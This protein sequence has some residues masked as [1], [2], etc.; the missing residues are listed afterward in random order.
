MGKI[1]MHKNGT[2][3]RETGLKKSKLTVQTKRTEK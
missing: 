1:E 2:D 3:R